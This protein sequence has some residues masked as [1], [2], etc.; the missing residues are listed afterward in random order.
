MEQLKNYSVITSQQFIENFT[1]N[2]IEFNSYIISFKHFEGIFK[3]N[4]SVEYEQALIGAKIMF[5]VSDDLTKISRYKIVGY[6]E[7]KKDRVRDL[8]EKRKQKEQ[9]KK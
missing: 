6:E 9:N 3:I 2:D 7:P 8:L 5:N 4:R 1:W